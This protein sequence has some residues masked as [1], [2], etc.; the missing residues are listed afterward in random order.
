MTLQ[1]QLLE[2]VIASRDQAVL[3]SHL[4]WARKTMSEIET[5]YFSY[6]YESPNPAAPPMDLVSCIYDNFTDTAVSL[7]KRYVSL[8]EQEYK[9]CLA[10]MQMQS[11]FAIK[12]AGVVDGTVDQ[13]NGGVRSIGME[14]ES[15]CSVDGHV[16]LPPY[17]SKKSIC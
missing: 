9:L 10:D 7:Q 13:T 3:A 6:H 4:Q 17:E 16:D 12:H 5:F 14:L 1:D 11:Q 15:S 8:K 2:L